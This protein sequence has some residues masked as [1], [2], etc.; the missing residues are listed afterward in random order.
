MRKN[1]VFIFIAGI[2]VGMMCVAAIGLHPF[3]R[4]VIRKVLSPVQKPLKKVKKIIS[5]S[6]KKPP[7]TGILSSFDGDD[8]ITWGGKETQREIVTGDECFDGACL[9][10]TYVVKDYPGLVSQKLAGDWSDYQT[11]KFDIN[12][13]TGDVVKFG[14]LIKDKVGGGAYVDRLDRMFA[15]RPGKSTFVFNITGLRTNGTAR[16]MD[17]DQIAEVI[18]FLDNPKEETTL[19][20]DNIRLEKAP[21]Y[22]N[23]KAPGI[24]NDFDDMNVAQ[25]G[26]NPKANIVQ[27]KECVAGKCLKVVY[28]GKQ[29][30]PGLV[31]QYVPH[32]WSGFDSFRMDVFNPT[33]EVI[34]FG[35]LL[36]DQSGGHQ[37]PH[38]YDGNFA[39]RPGLNKFVLNITGLK[40]NDKK[41]LMRMNE[42]MEM[43]IFLDHP[44]KDQALYI[45]NIRL[46]QSN[47]GL[48]KDIKMFDFGTEQSEVWP[49][50]TAVNRHTKYQ[51]DMGYGWHTMWDLK[52]EDRRYPDPLL[53]DW[54]RGSGP[55]GVDVPN[56]EYSV[57]IMIEDPG[58][59]EYY[60]NYKYRKVI[61]EDQEVIAETMNATEFFSDHYFY[62][63]RTDDHPGSDIFKNYVQKRF[64]WRHFKTTVKDGQ[65]SLKFDPGNAY[66]NTVSALIVA[67]VAQ[68]K[69][70]YEFL[71]ELEKQ[72]K[73]YFVSQY[74]EKLPK[75]DPLSPELAKQFQ[76]KAFIPFHQDFNEKLYPHQPPR[77]DQIQSH[78][79][80]QVAQGE[81]EP[82]VLGLYGLT[83]EQKYRIKIDDL[84]TAEGQAFPA[85]N[86]RVRPVQYKNKRVDND[87]VYEIRGELL[88]DKQS[89]KVSP[90]LVRH[91][92]FTVN[93]PKA[94]P[95]GLYKA[96]IFVC[97][98]DTEEDTQC[99][100]PQGFEIA[101]NVLPFTLEELDIPMGLFYSFP[102]QYKWYK[103]PRLNAWTAA[104]KQFH[105]M[106]EHGMNT[107]AWG[108][109][110][111]IKKIHDNGFVE[112]DFSFFDEVLRAYQHFGFDQPISGYGLNGIF[113]EIKKKTEGN[114]TQFA[115]AVLSA[116]S[117][118]S[119]RSQKILGQPMLIGIADEV[120]NPGL[121]GIDSI[122]DVA[123]ILHKHN[124]PATG[125]FND[126]K[127]IVIFPKMHTVTMS[128]RIPFTEKLFNDIQK[129]GSDIWIYN[130]GMDRF[131][132]GFY[133]WRVKADGRVQWHYQLPAVDPYND[134]DGREMD[135]C[136]SYPSLQGPIN[137]VSFELMAEGIEDYRYL[138]TL[139]TL[140]AK[141][142]N[143]PAYAKAIEFG[144]S[145][146]ENIRKNIRYNF[147]QNNW[148]T[149]ELQKTRQNIGRAIL[150]FQS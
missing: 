110:P 43:V 119:E 24:F 67:P 5:S 6:G 124:I 40:T 145:V 82:F 111:P 87:K 47:K 127:D 117:Q 83:E 29:E 98:S 60:Q 41:R 27:A 115:K 99:F 33:E 103:D 122:K 93:V 76:G 143:D 104:E 22:Q 77:A 105:D 2:V 28:P 102:F 32:D 149:Q 59:W 9:K 48:S 13:P 150:G 8:A 52:M 101:L 86:I 121:P 51:T 100:Q 36:K 31:S 64:A 123:H 3:G 54:V 133:P 69:E 92:W 113:K 144:K 94:T 134:L 66:A 37:Y 97:P 53:R 57:Y 80:I 55:F 90:N 116:Y 147:K 65:L 15:F 49:G 58:F 50:F 10:A 30:Y 131:S 42:I 14:I 12:N 71:K 118:I 34:K 126:T 135:F 73:E 128:P 79:E 81:K 91:V 112:M 44:Q 1:T 16:Q 89:V 46:E 62:H 85:K 108:V 25:W 68:E 125:Y 23:T 45:D 146:L 106:R 72:R 20:F 88:R 21:Q 139:E 18:L 70:A 120:S 129:N 84:K 109:K 26:G 38:R 4:K 130:M 136:A 39:L 78:V 138:R 11:L 114:K 17:I 137:A 95:A 63:L 148:S 74:I 56:G 96:P 19:Y 7:A 35:L 142:N 132:F 141:H 75:V 61:A 107:M 140:I